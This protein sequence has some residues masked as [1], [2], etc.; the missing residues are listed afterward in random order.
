MNETEEFKLLLDRRRSVTAFLV[1]HA[2]SFLP[3]QKEAVGLSL[4]WTAVV[5]P[6]QQRCIK[7]V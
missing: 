6:E 1:D 4:D 2:P 3:S 7:T 5:D